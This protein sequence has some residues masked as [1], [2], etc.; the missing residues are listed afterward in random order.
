M[1]WIVLALLVIVIAGTWVRNAAEKAREE[2][3]KR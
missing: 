1:L 3:K 2:D